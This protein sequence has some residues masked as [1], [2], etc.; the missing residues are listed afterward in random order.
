MTLLSFEQK[1]HRIRA[2]HQNA[3]ENL[4]PTLDNTHCQAGHR[5]ATRWPD[6][7]SH[8]PHGET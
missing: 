4:S 5:P 2:E 7:R 3:D 1:A 6:S 8:G